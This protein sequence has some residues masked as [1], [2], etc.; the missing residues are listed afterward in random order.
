MRVD[1]DTGAT[2]RLRADDV[3]AL[4]LHPGV[5]IDDALLRAV[6]E[7]SLHLAASEAARRLL[8]VRPRSE[9]ELRERLL[10]RGLPDPTVSAVIGELRA[11]GLVDDRRF[12]DAWVR[13]RLAL[14]PS[15]RVRL[16]Y[17]L[18]TRGVARD[19]VEAV[20]A[21]ALPAGDE[22]TLARHVA[23]ARLRR[24][25]GLPA[26]VASRRLAGVLLRRGFATSIVARVLRDLFGRALEP[27]P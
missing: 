13:D 16:R 15:G 23:S 27:S 26:E 11:R 17:E 10:R 1:L 22:L 3:A 12:A 18:A 20:L 4:D 19:V 14:R 5:E 21:Q 7:R 8:A 9:R 25:R 24:Y 6:R 2:F